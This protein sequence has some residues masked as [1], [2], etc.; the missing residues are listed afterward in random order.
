[1]NFKGEKLLVIAPHPDDEVLGCFGLMDLIR[2]TGG[3]VFVQVMTVGG[4]QRSDDIYVDQDT[5]KQEFHNVCDKQGVSGSDIM[6]DEHEFK[7][8]DQLRISQIIKYIESES[9]LSVHKLQPS[10]VA[11]PT[12]FSTHQDH[13]LSYK[14]AITAL[15]TNPIKGRVQPKMILSYE[16]PEYNLWS[17][18]VEM[19]NFSPNFYLPI[20]AETLGRKCEALESYQTQIKE[21]RRGIRA[22]EIQASMR[23]YQSGHEYAEAFNIQRLIVE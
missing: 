4:Y 8:L 10:V 18:Y 13:R 12:L 11:V 6:L 22:I 7:S 17:P 1:M 5:W 3:D 21:G 14:A 19:G 2:R 23:G 20:S 16:A 9:P 15:R